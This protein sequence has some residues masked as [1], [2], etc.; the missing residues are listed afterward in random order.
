ME[1]SKRAKLDLE[2]SNYTVSELTQ[3]CPIIGAHS[4]LTSV[5][6]TYA[7]FFLTNNTFELLKHVHMADE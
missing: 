5:S 3:S 4:F 7:A 6:P 1:M 2:E